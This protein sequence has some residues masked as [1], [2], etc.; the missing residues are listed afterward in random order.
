MLLYALVMFYS[1]S[2]YCCM[3]IMKNLSS[4]STAVFGGLH[5]VIVLGDFHQFPPVQA[6][7][8]WQ[9][10]GSNDE[11]RGQQLWQMFKDV[12]LLDEQ[13]RQQHDTAYH[14]LLQR[15]RNATITQ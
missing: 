8:L 2:L 7:A 11:K 5:V 9:N 6:K 3:K 4:N 10:Q 14:E 12:V 1:V 15:A 13:M